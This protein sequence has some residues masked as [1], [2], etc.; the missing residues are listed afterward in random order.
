MTASASVGAAGDARDSGSERPVYSKRFT[1]V[2]LSLNVALSIGIVI[3]NKSIYTYYGFP[4]ISM[5]CIHF[6][7]TTIGELKTSGANH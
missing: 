7:C 2:C 6:I 3:I 4:N 5:T 1:A